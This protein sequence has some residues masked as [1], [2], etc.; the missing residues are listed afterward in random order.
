MTHKYAARSVTIDGIKFASQAEGRRY[1]HLKLLQKAGE[2]TGLQV[3][4]KWIFEHNG[5]RLGAYTADFAYHDTTGALIVE[6]VK[7][8]A[9]KTTAYRL[10]VRM[11]FAFH[12]QE[13]WEVDARGN[14]QI[15][16]APPKSRKTR[17]QV[18]DEAVMA[19]A[20]LGARR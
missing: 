11:L 15:A 4:P 19:K 13:V 6:D 20:N 9:T 14:R 3:Q 18:I 7:S 8:D 16:F 10:R 12:A 17:R 2:I 1:S 5:V